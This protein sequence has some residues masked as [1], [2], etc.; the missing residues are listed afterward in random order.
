MYNYIFQIPP[1][2]N[3]GLPFLQTINKQ[4]QQHN[5]LALFDKWKEVKPVSPIIV[6]AQQVQIT[7]QIQLFFLV[8]YERRL[9][10]SLKS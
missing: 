2:Y 10:I 7:S 1:N 5:G 3:H 4:L 8:I 9:I 6:S